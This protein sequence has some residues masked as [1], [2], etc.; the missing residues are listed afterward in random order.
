MIKS[1]GLTHIHLY[2]RDLGRSLVFYESVFGLTEQFRDGPNMVFRS[3][4]PVYIAQSCYS[5]NA[6]KNAFA[7][8]ISTSRSS[9]LLM[10]VSTGTASKFGFAT[11]PPR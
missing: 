6:A 2:V 4:F 11:F 3:L 7:D 1:Q 5:A 9:R 10:S 8:A